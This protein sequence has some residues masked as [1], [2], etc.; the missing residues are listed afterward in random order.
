VARGLTPASLS[1][2]PTGLGRFLNFTPG[3]RP[4]LSYGVPPGLIAFPPGLIGFPPELVLSLR[5]WCS[6]SGTGAFPPEL[7][8]FPPRLVLPSGTGPFPPGLLPSL[9]DYCLPSGTDC[10]PSRTGAFP[11][12]PIGF[13]RSALSLGAPPHAFLSAETYAGGAHFTFFAAVSTAASMASRSGRSNR[14]P[15]AT[16]ARIFLVL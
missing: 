11:L 16:T 3:L 14:R 9:Q 7:V 10:F 13:P 15:L 4:G 5:N 1:A 12:G 2:A 6:P 8:A